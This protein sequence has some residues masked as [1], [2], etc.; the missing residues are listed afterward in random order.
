MCCDP[1]AADRLPPRVAAM[2]ADYRA[3][4]A[5][6]PADWGAESDAYHHGQPYGR[7]L[8]NRLLEAVFSLRRD[9]WPETVRA[10]LTDPLPAALRPALRVVPGIRFM[11]LSRAL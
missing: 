3:L 9:D 8:G 11:R 1:P 5:E 4:A 10:C 2:L 7:W 6:R